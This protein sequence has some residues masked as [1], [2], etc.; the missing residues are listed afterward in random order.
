MKVAS[1]PSFP[2]LPNTGDEIF[3]VDDGGGSVEDDE[4][5]KKVWVSMGGAMR[6]NGVRTWLTTHTHKQAFTKK[7]CGAMT[8]K[9]K[10]CTNKPSQKMYPRYVSSRTYSYVDSS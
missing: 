9:G 8:Q 7:E 5:P 1:S 4:P 6:E 2:K 3:S 10:P